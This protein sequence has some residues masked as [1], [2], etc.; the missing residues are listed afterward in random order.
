MSTAV[1]T[2]TILCVDDHPLVR[3][4]IAAILANEAV[5]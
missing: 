3:K 1:S 4:G 2:I 5:L